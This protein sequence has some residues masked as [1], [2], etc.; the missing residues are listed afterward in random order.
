MMDWNWSVVMA[1]FGAFFAAHGQAIGNG[2]MK[3]W[4]MYLDKKYPS[5]PQPSTLGRIEKEGSP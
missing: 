5:P 4:E 2:L 3:A 1:A